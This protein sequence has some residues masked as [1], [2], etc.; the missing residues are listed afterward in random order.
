MTL[1]QTQQPSFAQVV[2][3]LRD[4]TGCCESEVITE[5][6]R[7]EADLGVTGDDGVELLEAAERVFNVDFV[8]TDGFRSTF[9]LAENEYLFGPE[10]IDIFAPIVI[11]IKFILR[12]P[13]TTHNITDLTAGELHKAICRARHRPPNP[14]AE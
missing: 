9:G 10:G 14:S 1:E 13:Q 7:L 2:A 3:F 6:T 8:G 12:I 11:L 4:A 5:H